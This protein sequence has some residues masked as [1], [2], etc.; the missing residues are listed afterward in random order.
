[1]RPKE[2]FLDEVT[3]ELSIDGE[4]IEGFFKDNL[5]EP[6]IEAVKTPNIFTSIFDLMTNRRVINWAIRNYLPLDTTAILYGESGAGKSFMAL[7]MALHVATGREWHGHKVRQGA[8]FY[9]AGEGVGGMGARCKAWTIANNEP[10]TELTPFYCSSGA[11]LLP[12]DRNMKVLLSL[13]IS[14]AFT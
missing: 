1:M 5:P 7:D 12:D 11:V 6:E 9:I 13:E 14:T 4:V 2:L 8:V 10:M 3:G